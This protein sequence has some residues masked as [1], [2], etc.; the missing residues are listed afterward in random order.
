M[1]TTQAQKSI[2]RRAVKAVKKLECTTKEAFEIAH[3]YADY[4]IAT[5]ID[6]PCMGFDERLE[7]NY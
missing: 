3:K 5:E 1:M 2:W 6:A 7:N 4:L